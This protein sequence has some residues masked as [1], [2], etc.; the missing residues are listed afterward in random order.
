MADARDHQRHRQGSA[1]GAVSQSRRLPSW[2]PLARCTVVCEMNRCDMS[3]AYDRTDGRCY[4]CGKKADGLFRE[5]TGRRP[6]SK[7]PWDDWFD[8][9]EHV[10]HPT[11]SFVNFVRAARIAAKCRGLA[12]VVE[13]A[14]QAVALRALLE[15]AA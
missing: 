12:V 4:Y 6:Y 14:G 11:V 5:R 7:Y 10:V 13:H 1:E 3:A 2:H 15:V 9:N 8:G